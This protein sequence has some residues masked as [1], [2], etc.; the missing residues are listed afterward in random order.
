MLL[1]ATLA[2][3]AFGSGGLGAGHAFS[4]ALETDHGLTHARAVAVMLPHIMEF[5]KIGVLRRYEAIAAALGERVGEP[6][7]SQTADAAISCVRRMLEATAISSR[8]SDYGVS[9]DNI[10]ALVAGTMRQSRLFAANPRNLTE[11]DVWNIYTR[12]LR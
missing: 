11:Q 10:P 7:H 2:G 12:A 9:D 3:L 1:A 8:L 6:S 5:N 4:F